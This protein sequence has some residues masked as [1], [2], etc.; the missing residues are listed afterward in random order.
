MAKLLSRFTLHTYA[1]NKK[2]IYLPLKRY[3]A[4]IEAR[5]A[6][7]KEG[8]VGTIWVRNPKYYVNVRKLPTRYGIH[9]IE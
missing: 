6:D 9:S 4:V 3:S 2:K 5:T 7:H 8:P 1:A